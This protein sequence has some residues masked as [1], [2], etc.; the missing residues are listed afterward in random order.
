VTGAALTIEAAFWDD[1]DVRD[2]T[3]AQQAEVRARYGGK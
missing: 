3:T 2:L 1:A